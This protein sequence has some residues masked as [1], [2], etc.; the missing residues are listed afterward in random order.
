M[1]LDNTKLKQLRESNAWSQSHLAEASGISMRTIQRIEKTGVA[2]PESAKCI[3]AAFDIRFDELALHD[4]Y[5]IPAPTLT[6]SLKLKVTSIDK[7]AALISFVVAF[8]IA[9]GI[10][11]YFGVT[12]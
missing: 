11:I 4:N 10:T 7:K 5:Q 1:K 6:D 9:Y 2:S 12:I 3:C 8:I